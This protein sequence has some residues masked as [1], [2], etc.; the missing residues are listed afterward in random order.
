[1][2]KVPD[3]RIWMKSE[4]ERKGIWEWHAEGPNE[5]TSR[6]YS[7]A[8]QMLGKKWFEIFLGWINDCSE[9]GNIIQKRIMKGGGGFFCLEMHEV[10]AMSPKPAFNQDFKWMQNQS[11]EKKLTRYLDSS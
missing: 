4:R 6:P 11:F 2:I 7:T 9:M 10:M 3:P 1:M 8:V 5:E